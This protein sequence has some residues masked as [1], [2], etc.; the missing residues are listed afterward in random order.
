MQILL[1]S[2]LR[3]LYRTS[4]EVFVDTE[5]LHTRHKKHNTSPQRK[6]IE[7][8]LRNGI[9][10]CPEVYIILDALDEYLQNF[11]DGAIRELLNVFR[12]LGSNVKLMVTSRVLGAMEGIFEEF[13]AGRLEI[14]AKEEDLQRYIQ[15]RIKRDVTCSPN[16]DLSAKIVQKVKDASNGQYV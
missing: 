14:C 15:V 1:A 4:P 10:R 2:L 9:A 11:S 12:G 13:R 5:D 6:E 16:E 3:Q 8:V 7:E